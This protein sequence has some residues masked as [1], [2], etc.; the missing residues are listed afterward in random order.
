MYSTE[1]DIFVKAQ[2]RLVLVL[3]ELNSDILE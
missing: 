3:D 1:F 2:S